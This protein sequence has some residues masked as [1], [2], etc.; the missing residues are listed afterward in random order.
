MPEMDAIEAAHRDGGPPMPGLERLHSSH[1]F[2][3][4]YAPAL[5]M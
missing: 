4:D 2:H 1:E 3:G 5:R